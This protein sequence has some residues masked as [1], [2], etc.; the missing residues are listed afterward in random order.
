MFTAVI[1]AT[2]LPMSTSRRYHHGDLRAALL[3][4]TRNVLADVGLE[5]LSL[6]E[7]SRIAGVSHAAAYN[8]FADKGAL[9]QAVVAAAFERL[10]AELRQARDRAAPRDAYGVLIEIGIAYVR[11]AYLNRADFRIMFRPELCGAVDPAE[12]RRNEEAYS[13]LVETVEACQAG[14]TVVPGSPAPLVLAAWS[15][16]HGLA[17]LIVDGPDP[18]L[19]PTLEAAETL[20]RQCAGLLGSGLRRAAPAAP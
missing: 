12:A 3:T 13:I 16:V 1:Y 14:A 17:S 19:A 5:G 6:R 9:L 18:N 10:G 2:M 8:H 11:F 7:V 4:A 15:M 20:A